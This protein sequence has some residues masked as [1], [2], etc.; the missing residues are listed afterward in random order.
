LNAIQHIVLIGSGNVAT[1]LGLAIQKT[2]GSIVQVYSRTEVSAM[3]LAGLLNADF[4]CVMEDIRRE[5]DLYI[6]AVSDD[7]LSEIAEDLNLDQKMVVH[8]SGSLP[9]DILRKSSQNYGVL[10]PLQTFS[11]SREI[12]FSVIPLC[13]EANSKNNLHLLEHFARELSH[14][15]EPIDSETRKILHLAAVF[16]CNFPNFM[17]HIAAQIMADHGL[18]FELLRPLILETAVKVQELK[19]EEAQT[20]PA[21][22]R[23]EEIMKKHIRL[24][25]KFPEFQKIYNMLSEGIQGKAKP[26]EIIE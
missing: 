25:K 12:D 7:A 15:V 13:I 23:D 8:T 4:T 24:L 17:Y 22:R 18:Q 19:P 6:I 3:H 14:K 10:Y 11:K 16:A 5:A 26:F 2:G 21:R 20:G 9:M 1:H